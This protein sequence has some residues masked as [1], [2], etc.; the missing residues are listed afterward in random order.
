LL[1]LAALFHDA[2]KPSTRFVDERGKIRF[3]GHEK[4]SG[5]IF[6]DV[7]ARIR[8][9]GDETQV[10]IDWIHGHMRPIALFN[11]AV[12]RRMVYR[13]WKAFGQEILGLFLLFLS[14]LD[15]TRGPARAD[16]SDEEAWQSVRTVLTIALDLQKAPPKP[17]VNGRDLMQELAFSPG[18]ELGHIL[19]RLAE[20]QASGEISSREE[21]LAAAKQLV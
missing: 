17:L 11:D 21:A 9:S 8:L 14:D 4:V 20:M 12:T 18:P 1:K 10:V 16:R 19:A 2:G 5:P 15:A 3:F 6:G 13:L 7:A